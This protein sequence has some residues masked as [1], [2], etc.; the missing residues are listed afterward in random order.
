MLLAIDIGNSNIIIGCVEREKIIFEERLGTDLNKTEL[1]YAMGIRMIFELYHIDRSDV[2]GVILSS[3]VPPLTNVIKAAVRKIIDKKIMTVGPG[4]KTG[5]NIHMDDPRSVGAD[6]V[7]EAVAAINRYGAPLIVVDMGTATSICVIDKSCNYIGGMIVPGVEI[8]MDALTERTS[9]LPKIS[10]EPPKKVV[11]RNTEDSMKSGIIC[12]TASMVDG[13][14]ERV[15]DECRFKATVVAGSNRISRI[16]VPFCKKEII[17]DNELILSG[18]D[19][20]YRK[21]A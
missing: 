18:L 13:L 6:L 3:V 8:S 2:E 20:I 7:V 5:L 12:G 16:I 15:E 19:L 21:N 10:I 17:L 11:G 1:E 4:V 14:I 9:Q